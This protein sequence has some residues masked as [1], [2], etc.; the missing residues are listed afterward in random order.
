MAVAISASLCYIYYND[1]VQQD[2][3][4]ALVADR[5]RISEMQRHT[6]SGLANL[7]ETRATETGEH[8][9]RTSSY[10]R[11][12][13][14]N[15][16]RDGVYADQ[17]DDEFISRLYSL[18]P[19]HDVG[20][21]V[22]SDSILRK[23]G[24]LTP[25]EFEQM[26]LHASAGGT[27]VRQILEGVTDEDYLSFASDIATYHHERW[28]GTGY[29][30]GLSGEAIPLSAR[31]MAITDVFDALISERCY[32]EAMPADEAAELIRS[33]AGSHFDPKLAAVFLEHI[34]G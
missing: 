34:S 32:K 11:S 23:P 20:K 17:I 6:I 7:I 21:I 25:E 29:P 27:V 31:I 13:A 30:E 16:R 4:A 1:L 19:L 3:Q 24:K 8:V 26:K 12:I 22:V 28:D 9:A 14:E 10:V 15:A 33:E 5:D 18:A 2:I